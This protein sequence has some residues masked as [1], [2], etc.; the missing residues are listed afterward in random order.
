M[1]KRGGLHA[2]VVKDVFMNLQWTQCMMHWEVLESKE[3]SAMLKV[4]M[5][6]IIVTETT[7]KQD[8]SIFPLCE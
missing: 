5:H 3:M 1:E 6:V 4:V 8:W 2:L 7:S